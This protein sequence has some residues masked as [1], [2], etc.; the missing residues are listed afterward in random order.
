MLMT[1]T[2]ATAQAPAAE[3]TR[4]HSLRMTPPLS[5]TVG[6]PFDVTIEF[7]DP[8]GKP[9]ADFET[10]G[11]DVTIRQGFPGATGRFEP[12]RIARA[13]FKNGLARV[14]LR[15][16]VV[17]T[18]ALQVEA[19]PIRGFSVPFAVRAK[20][21]S[22]LNDENPLRS[23][24]LIPAEQATAGKPFM[25][26]IMGKTDS[27]DI[28]SDWSRQKARIRIFTADDSAIQAPIIAV[29]SFRHG[30][31]F[32]TVIPAR[33]G[34]I[35]LQAI[36]EISHAEGRSQPVRVGTGLATSPAIAIAAAP[37]DTMAIAGINL[38]TATLEEL[39]AIPEIG[40]SR[41]KILLWYREN[42]RPI[43]TREDLESV[44]GFDPA[45][46]KA[47]LE[48]GPAIPLPR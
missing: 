46:V 3:T 15:Y 40:S 38:N 14:R 23:L 2:A 16:S 44:P 33:A 9:I 6:E 12:S 21:H 5:A 29:E 48:K 4:A 32:L 28:I 18:A 37:T 41:A 8:D 30:I 27:G 26:Q 42:S 39:S 47:L 24:E 13:L 7:L 31:A 34:T 1:G 19:A 10:A 36:D 17:E 22:V 20:A 35:V 11:G 43:L 45:R 25:L